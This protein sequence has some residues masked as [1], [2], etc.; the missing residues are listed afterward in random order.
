LF[1][2][3]IKVQPITENKAYSVLLNVEPEFVGYMWSKTWMYVG[4]EDK[5][6]SGENERNREEIRLY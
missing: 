5:K 2:V 3:K 6:Q 4:N 1:K